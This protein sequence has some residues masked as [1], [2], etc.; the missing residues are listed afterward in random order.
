MDAGQDAPEIRGATWRCVEDEGWLM[1]H[2]KV[3]EPLPYPALPPPA[4]CAE[5]LTSTTLA[6][7]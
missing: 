6:G 7:G 1:V 3:F 5:R 4:Q 2:L